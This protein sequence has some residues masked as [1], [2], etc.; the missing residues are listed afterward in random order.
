MPVADGRATA[1]PGVDSPGDV[2]GGAIF[3]EPQERSRR[4]RA[5]ETVTRTNAGG[6]RRHE[7][8]KKAHV[9]SNQRLG[10]ANAASSVNGGRERD[11]PKGGCAHGGKGQP[12][13]ASIHRHR[14]TEGRS[15]ARANFKEGGQGARS[16]AARF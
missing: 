8:S 14:A 16:N 11:Y 1:R 4:C 2:D 15:E 10:V 12:P 7:S 3:D 13:A 6:A 5:L 9:A